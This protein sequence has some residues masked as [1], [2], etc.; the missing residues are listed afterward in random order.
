MFKTSKIIGLTTVSNEYTSKVPGQ[1]VSICR[2][3]GLLSKMPT[4][5][6]IFKGVRHSAALL[7][8]IGM[9]I[10][11][12]REMKYFLLC[13]CVEVVNPSGPPWPMWDV[14]FDD[15]GC[16]MWLGVM[17]RV[18]MWHNNRFYP[19]PVRYSSLIWYSFVAK[20]LLLRH[21]HRKI[22]HPSY[23]SVE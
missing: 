22:V 10:M 18:T 21:L 5:L 6:A 7:W 16:G 13:L 14:V 2:L 1:D 17:N 4:F 11:Q 23:R 20:A 3:F 9:Q 15:G 8:L 12:L 19:P